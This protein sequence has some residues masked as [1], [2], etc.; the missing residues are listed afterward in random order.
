MATWP[1]KTNYATGDVLTAAEMQDIGNALNSV[2]SAQYAAGKNKIINGNFGIWQRGTS[3]TLSG[4]AQLFVTDR[5]YT[6]A[7]GTGGTVT[8]SQ[9]AFTAGTAPVSGYEGSFFYRVNCSS[10]RTG[11]TFSGTYHKI[12]D[13]RTLAGQTVTI[14]FWGKAAT[15]VSLNSAIYQN[16]GSGGSSQ[17]FVGDATLS[18]TT[19]WQR[20]SYTVTMPSISGKTI[21]TGSHLLLG[22]SLPLNTTYTIDIWGVQVE[23]SSTATA[24]Q[25]AT[26]T[27]AGELAACQRYYYLHASGNLK[28]IGTGFYQTA[29]EINGTVQFPVTMRTA[30]SLVVAN[31]TDYYGMRTDGVYDFFDTFVI[32]VP[33]QN[34]A[35]IYRDANVAGTQGE[36]GFILTNNAA[37]SIAFNSEL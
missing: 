32:F 12:E 24:F 6:Q 7:D 2:E 19:S 28:A 9:Q 14:S 17:V 31:G 27:L 16:F 10:A 25:T 18:Y 13:V 20:F 8:I 26:G 23:A 1:A 4:T 5:F 21:G 3:G 34:T 29:T 33:T 22:I 15:N 30:P 37:S 35:V 36:A 11:S